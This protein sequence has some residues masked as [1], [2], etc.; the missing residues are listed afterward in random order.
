MT[1]FELKD[2]SLLAE[3]VP[4]RMA[5]ATITIGSVTVYGLTV[6]RSKNG[7]L[8]VLWPSYRIQGPFNVYQ[9]TVE[10]GPDLR[11]Q[12]EASIISAYRDMK[13]RAKSQP[14]TIAPF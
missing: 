2:I 3:Q 4:Q 8:R 10:I 14:G 9:D 13:K 5:T 6:W 12:I 1:P 7:H 11:E